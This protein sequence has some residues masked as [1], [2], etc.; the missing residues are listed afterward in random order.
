MFRDAFG[1][2]C[3]KCRFKGVIVCFQPDL[4]IALSPKPQWKMKQRRIEGLSS[5]GSC[6][7]LIWQACMS[8][9]V[10][11]HAVV[12]MRRAL[13]Q[14]MWP[15]VCRFFLFTAMTSSLR[16]SPSSMNSAY[17]SSYICWLCSV[18]ARTTTYCRCTLVCEYKQATKDNVCGRVH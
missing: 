18:I 9:Q 2:A 17:P 3:V 10:S 12:V 15:S 6:R 4:I 14:Y 5:C 1:N 8:E 13:T 11:A 16:E 7:V